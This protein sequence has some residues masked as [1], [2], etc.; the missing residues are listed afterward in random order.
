MTRGNGLPEL[1]RPRA[2]APARAGAGA[3]EGQSL[4]EVSIGLGVLSVVMLPLALLFF[5][6]ASASA[7]SREYGDAIAIANGFL[8]KAD[9]ITYADLGFYEDQFG[10]PPLTVPGYGLQPGVDLG[11]AP[12]AGVSAQVPV[13]STAQQVGAVVFSERTYVVWVDGSGGDAYA[14]KQVYAVVSWTEGGRAVSV[15]QNILVYPGGLGKYSGPQDNAPGGTTGTPDNVA[16]LVATVPADPGGET[17]VG[18][19][20]L[21]PVDPTGYYA[22]VWSTSAASLAPP[23]SAGTSGA[24]APSGTTTS[25]AIAGSATGFTVTGL[26]PSTAYWFEIVA[27][28]SDGSQWAVSQSAVTATTLPAPGQPCTL[29]TLAV[30]QAGQSSGQAAVAKSNGHLIGP[31]SITVSYSGSCT[32]S[33]DSVTVAASSSGSDPGTPYTLT[34]G[35]TQY[36]YSL[37]PATGLNTGTHTYTVS[38]NGTTTSLTAQ[39]SFSQDK[40]DTPAC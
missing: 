35:S 22:A 11:A 31:I 4:L 15:V 20:W 14:Y 10:T 34:W 25:G 21:A 37:C 2:G 13:T 40:K 38:H 9:A 23:A 32:S 5:S 30:S 39:V 28:S 12:P 19:S 6:G 36:S 1:S 16:G 3:E 8:A 33:S 26:S 17:A 27:F 24:W 7:Q 18:L 29:G